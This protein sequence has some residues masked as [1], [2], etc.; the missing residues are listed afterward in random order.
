MKKIL[1]IILLATI[2][3]VGCKDKSTFST[4]D[5]K[6]PATATGQD[7]AIADKMPI[8]TFEKITHDF[9]K[10]IHGERVVYHYKFTNTGKSNLIINDI[11]SSC[12]CTTTSPP[13]EPIRP[14]ESSDIKLIFDSKT[15]S[16]EVTNHLVVYANT[17]P[18]TTVLTMHAKIINF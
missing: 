4:K 12:G 6:N 17:Y 10:V 13:Q 18:S 7:A 3:M 16:G 14:G 11:E 5:I 8:I 9:G 1:P 15:K 2:F